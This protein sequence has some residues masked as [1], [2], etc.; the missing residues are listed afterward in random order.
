MEKEQIFAMF[1][2]TEIKLQIT[3]GD[4][5]FEII[6]TVTPQ[7]SVADKSEK[8]AN[9]APVAPEYDYKVLSVKPS[10]KASQ[11]LELVNKKNGEVTAAYIKA[12]DQPIVVGSCLTEVDIQQ[13]TGSYGDYNLIN[14]CKVAA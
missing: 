12:G 1:E 6:G 8:P 11:L 13:K 4:N 9:E 7:I 3:K 2:N 14:A 5:G 10:G